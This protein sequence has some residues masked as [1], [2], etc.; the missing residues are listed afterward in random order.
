VQSNS[1]TTDLNRHAI[2]HSAGNEGGGNTNCGLA[3]LEKGGGGIGN[4]LMSNSCG[5]LMDLAEME[6]GGGGDGPRMEAAES[7]QRL[8]ISPD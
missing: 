2:E 6:G 8:L 3:M 4:G 1:L 5:P 7:E